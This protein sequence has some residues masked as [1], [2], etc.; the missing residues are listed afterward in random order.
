[1]KI[2]VLDGFTLNPGDLSWEELETLGEVTIHERTPP[3]LILS[4]AEGAEII[5]TNKTPLRSEVIAQLPKLRYIGVLATGFDV[6][7]LEAAKKQ[8]VVVTN[9]PAYSSDSVAQMVF[10]LLL[11]LSI[12]VGE[13]SAAV[14]KGNWSACKDFCFWI[15][16]LHELAGKTMGIIGYGRIGKRVAEIAEVYGMH[17]LI[18]DVVKVESNET[19]TPQWVELPELF[20]KSDVISLHC[21]LTADTQGMINKETLKL[22]KK[23]AFLINTARGKLIVEEDLAEALN[24]G[25]IAGAGLDVLSVEPPGKDNPLLQAVNCII[26]PHIA[27]ATKEAR[28][29]LL[30]IAVDNI[31]AFLKG[32][33]VNVVN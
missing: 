17:V 7:D 25:M 14:R 29:R 23:S 24:K 10:A 9:V 2:V 22:M 32:C 12:H 26:T 6:V 20:R 5:L 15:H 33:P 28:I 31:K 8:N 13:H 30:R 27:W 18:H 1:M 16:P 4:R 11:E 21:P 19:G 3:E